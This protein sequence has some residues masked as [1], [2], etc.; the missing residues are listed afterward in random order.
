MNGEEKN[1]SMFF[2]G[3]GKSLLI[4]YSPSA[5]LGLSDLIESNAGQPS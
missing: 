1:N 5:A 4:A 3:D 2:V